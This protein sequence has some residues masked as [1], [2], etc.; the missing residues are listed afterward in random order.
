MK[1][2]KMYAAL[3]SLLLLIPII[4]SSCGDDRTDD[5]AQNQA[6]DESN[7]TVVEETNDVI[8]A[9]NILLQ[10]DKVDMGGEEINILTSN[11][12]NDVIKLQT[13]PD[14]VQ[15]GDL[16]NDSLYE[17]DKMI[18]EYYNTSIVYNVQNVD[19]DIPGIFQKETLAGE[20]SFDFSIASVKQSVNFFNA[21]LTMNLS[22]IPHIELDNVWWSHNIMNHFSYDGNYHMLVGEFTP[23]NVFAGN[24]LIFNL[25]EH[26][27]RGLPNLY[28]MVRD[29]SWTIDEFESITKGL[30]QDL[31]GD[32]VIKHGDFFAMNNDSTTLHSFYYSTGNTFVTSDGNDLVD[33]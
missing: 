13:A 1:N 14:T 7:T 2:K 6:N 25:K 10:Y 8:N 20:T 5:S 9:S 32:G 16:I 21:G 11:N 26:K 27:N 30:A 19:G 31:D 12:L 28:D 33:K 24:V 3:L 29:G 15:N 4:C 17:R 22:D 18:E 23:R